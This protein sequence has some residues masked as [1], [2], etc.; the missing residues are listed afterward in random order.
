MRKMGYILVVALALALLATGLSWL[1]Q[2]RV[3][4]EGFFSLYQGPTY[5][6]HGWPWWF[7]RCIEQGGC[8]F[9]I[10]YFLLDVLFWIVVFLPVSL[11][12][13]FMFGLIRKLF[14]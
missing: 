12:C 14:W 11:G 13:L 5:Y 10:S 1:C 6:A 4:S 7:W 9:S 2:E 8:F 3:S